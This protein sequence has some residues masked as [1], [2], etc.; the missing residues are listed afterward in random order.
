MKQ[1]A[2]IHLFK[3][4]NCY[5]I[6]DVN[7]NLFLKVAKDIYEE[8]EKNQG[9][10]ETLKENSVINRLIDKGY[11]SSNRAEKIEHSLTDILEDALDNYL[12][13]LTLQITQQ[14][15]LRCSYCVYS[16]NYLNRSHSQKEMDIETAKKG[17]DFIIDHSKNS[18]KVNF[19]FY[20]G[21]PFL[22]F[23]FIKE[24]VAY[25]KLKGEGKKVTF[26]MT[27]NGTLINDEIMN[28]VKENDILLTISMDGPK[29]IHDKNRVFA[30]GM[31]SFDKIMK[32]V[33]E[34]KAKFPQY[35]QK[36]LGFNTVMDGKS[37]FGC[38]NNFFQS[39]DSVRNSNVNAT[40]INTLGSIE[41]NTITEDFIQKQQ[42]ERF[43]ILLHKLGKLDEVHTSRILLKEFNRLNHDLDKNREVSGKIP[44]K[45]HPGGPC[46]PGLNRLFMDVNGRFFPCERVSEESKVMNIGS[47]EKGFEIQRIKDLLNVGKTSEGK[48]KNCWAYRYCYLCAA[49]ADDMNELSGTKKC[50]FCNEVKNHAERMFKLYCTMKEF[51]CNFEEQY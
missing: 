45:T 29:E 34:I 42:Y 46:V 31:G 43:K 9:S 6:Y 37:D 40:I 18:S 35:A 5:Y 13:T 23:N 36:S 2:F 14:C 25:A 12:N 51:G 1:E 4:R 39:Y 30:N 38:I 22:R 21:E 48:C 16:G 3:T 10:I 20:G 27:T 8:L 28:F 24:C 32:N 44:K 41:E 17:I 50:K 26:S 7:T 47:V 11:L 33:D 49:F 15:N 19:S